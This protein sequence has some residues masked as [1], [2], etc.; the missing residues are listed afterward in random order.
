MLNLE[1]REQIRISIWISQ[2]ARRIMEKMLH[3]NGEEKS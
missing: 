1:N 2:K 3:K